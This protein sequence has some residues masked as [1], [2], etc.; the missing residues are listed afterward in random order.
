MQHPLPQLIAMKLSLYFSKICFLC[1]FLMVYQLSTP[2]ILFCTL[3]R[4]KALCARSSKANLQPNQ[5]LSMYFNMYSVIFLKSLIFPSVNVEKVKDLY[6]SESKSDSLC[7]SVSSRTPM[8][9][10]LWYCQKVMRLDKKVFYI[11][12]YPSHCVS[13]YSGRLSNVPFLWYWQL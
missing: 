2:V 6:L 5:H 4:F 8:G 1:V 11:Q 13:S 9:H 12:N 7:F 10:L 3:Q